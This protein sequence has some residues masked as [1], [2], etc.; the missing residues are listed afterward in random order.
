MRRIFNGIL[1]PM[2]TITEE[3]RQKTDYIFAETLEK[4]S[5]GLTLPC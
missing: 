5:L 4:V 1:T 2:Q 3:D